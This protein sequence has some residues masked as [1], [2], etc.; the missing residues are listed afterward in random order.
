MIDT[1]A[2][3]GGG[4]LA[5]VAGLQSASQSAEINKAQR[6]R[7]KQGD[8]QETRKMQPRAEEMAEYTGTDQRPDGPTTTTNCIIAL[9]MH[10][11]V[12]GNTVR[13]RTFTHVVAT[14]RQ[15]VGVAAVATTSLLTHV[16]PNSN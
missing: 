3:S 8:R 7:D 16:T 15:E 6:E 2:G 4:R 11:P 14:C 10:Q 12:V 1:R 5:T 9:L 13:F